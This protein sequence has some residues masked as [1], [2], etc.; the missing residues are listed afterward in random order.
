[1]ESRS[2]YQYQSTPAPQG[3]DVDVPGSRLQGGPPHTEM[4]ISSFMVYAGSV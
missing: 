4:L 2:Y 3:K 1:M